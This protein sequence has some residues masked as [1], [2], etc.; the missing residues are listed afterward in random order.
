MGRVASEVL[1][2]GPGTE[3]EAIS[4]GLSDPDAG[5]RAAALR[6]AGDLLGRGA[7]GDLVAALEDR[8]GLVQ[9]AA[10][11]AL[12]VIWRPGSGDEPGTRGMTGGPRDAAD[13]LLD[14]ASRGGARLC[15][16]AYEALGHMALA[17]LASVLVERL[18]AEKRPAVRRVIACTL[19]RLT[20]RSFGD[21]PDRWHEWI[22]AGGMA[23]RS[24]AG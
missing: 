11:R 7:S 5:V 21:D 15:T 2:G 8:D 23:G 16:A 12:G 13:A 14:S 24:P 4:A 10:A 6:A 18:R 1:S 22:G 17:E 19:R 20:G 3:R 9:V